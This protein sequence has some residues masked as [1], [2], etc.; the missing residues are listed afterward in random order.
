[1]EEAALRLAHSALAVLPVPLLGI[2]PGGMIALANGAAETLFAR[3]APL[4]GLDA[5]EVLPPEA[6]PLLNAGSQSA[7]IECAG[8][9]F[10]IEARPLDGEHGDGGLRGTLLSFTCRRDTP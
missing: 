5:T 10:R 8:H 6:A 4:I 1:M 3:H 7:D 9:R 2:D